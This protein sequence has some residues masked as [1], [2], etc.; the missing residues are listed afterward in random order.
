MPNFSY[1]GR[2]NLGALVRGELQGASAEAVADVL[3]G[4]GI[5]PLNI[6]QAKASR[7]PSIFLLNTE[8]IR[9]EEIMF[10]SRQ[11]FTLLKAG[12]PILRALLGLQES[13]T[14]PAMGKMLRDLRESLDSGRELSASLARQPKVYSPF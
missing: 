7:A 4:R 13:M 6:V 1:K 3:L 9:D 2:S 11:L 14:N 10:F 12:V 5:T 8:K